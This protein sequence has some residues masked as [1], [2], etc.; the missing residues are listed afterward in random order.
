MKR[1]IGL[2]LPIAALRL[3]AA[4][5]PIIFV[6]GHKSEADTVAGFKTWN[7]HDYTTV[8]QKILNSHYDGYTAGLPLNCCENTEL[9]PTPDAKRIY[10]FSYYHPQGNPG[11]I[12]LSEQKVKVYIYYD[13][14]G[15]KRVSAPYMEGYP[16]DPYDHIE[17]WPR[18]LPKPMEPSDFVAWNRTFIESWN[19]GRFAKRLADFI[20]KVL[21]KTGATK[22]DIVAHSMGGLV[23]RVAIKNYG[24][25]SKV[26]KLLM[27]ATPNHPFN[28]PL[29]TTLFYMFSGDK[30]WQKDG[31]DLEMNANLF[32]GDQEFI[33]LW[34]GED[35]LWHDWLGYDNY[36]SGGMS[37]IRGERKHKKIAG[38][39][40]G[41]DDGVVDISQAYLASATFNPIIYASHGHSEPHDYVV[42]EDIGASGELSLTECTYTTEFI[43]KW[44]I[45]DD[46]V[47]NGAF[48]RCPVIY[49]SQQTITPP[50]TVLRIDLNAY[51]YS[52]VLSILAKLKPEFETWVGI[53][54]HNCTP[55][56]PG[57][58]VFSLS[59]PSQNGYYTLEVHTYDMEGEIYYFLEEDSLTKYLYGNGESFQLQLQNP[60]G[61]EV[62]TAGESYTVRWWSNDM[63]ISQ[64]LYY[65][66]DSGVS[67][68]HF[69]S[70]NTNDE[71]QREADWYPPQVVTYNAKIKLEFSLDANHTFSRTSG[72]FTILAHPYNLVARA[73]SE[74]SIELCW[75]NP[76]TVSVS[77]DSIQIYRKP[78]LDGTDEYGR[79]DKVLD[80]TSFYTDNTVE[81]GI[82][83]Y[84]KVRAYVGSWESPFSDE[85]SAT[86]P[87]LSAPTEVTAAGISFDKVKL[88]WRDNSNYEEKYAI[89]R[90]IAGKSDT[91][92]WVDANPGTGQMEFI[93]NNLL[94]GTTYRYRIAAYETVH[95][96]S[97]T[98]YSKYARTFPVATA[99]QNGRK[100]ATFDN[101]ICMVYAMD[102][103]IWYK[104]SSNGG[105]NWSI[106]CL[107][108]E[109]LNCTHPA[110][111]ITSSGTRFVVWT[112]YDPTNPNRGWVYR[113]YSNDGII[114]EEPFLLINRWETITPPSIAIGRGDTVHMALTYR[115][116]AKKLDKVDPTVLYMRVFPE[117][118]GEDVYY[119]DFPIV[120]IYACVAIDLR[121]IPHVVWQ[122]EGKICTSKRTGYHKWTKPETISGSCRNCQFPSATSDASGRL[123]C[124]W[125]A[126][127][128]LYLS[129]CSDG[130]SWTAP[131]PIASVSLDVSTFPVI[132]T[133]DGNLYVAWNDIEQ[134]NFEIYM[135]EKK[136]N[137]DWLVPINI[138]N[139]HENSTFPHIAL[140]PGNFYSMWTEG[141]EPPFE[142]K[143]E[144]MLVAPEVTLIYPNGG[145]HLEIG[146]TYTITWDIK[147]HIKE[148][149]LEYTTDGVTWYPIATIT[150]PNLHSYDWKV[151]ELPS[152]NCRVRITVTN[153]IGNTALDESDANFSI[154]YLTSDI[155]E[156]TGYNNQRKLA[157]DSQD[158]LHLVFS[159]DN[160]VRYARST[161]YGQSWSDK[162][163]IGNGRFPALAVDN[164][165]KKNTC[166]INREGSED[167]LYY[168]K[169][170]GEP[171]ELL[172][173]ATGILVGGF[174]P[175]A[176]VVDD[177]DW[178]HIALKTVKL[179]EQGFEYV[180]R[181]RT[182]PVGHPE[183]TD[184][185][186]VASY[187]TW[188]EPKPLTSPSVDID[189]YQ[190]P[191]IAFTFPI[192][193]EE[194]TIYYAVKI[195]G[196]WTSRDI[197]KGSHPSM[198]IWD[199]YTNVV[200]QGE[201]T[202]IYHI[203]GRI[204]P[205]GI[206][207]S[208]I[209]KISDS[210][211]YASVY[212]VIVGGCE[213]LWSEEQP[214][215]SYQIYE[216]H[217]NGIGWEGPHDI[218]GIHTMT[219]ECFPQ[220]DI[221]VIQPHPG[222]IG[223]K[224]HYVYTSGNEAPYEIR[225]GSKDVFVPYLF[226][227]KITEDTE[228][229]RDVYITGDVII[230]SGVT[231]TIKPGVKIWASPW[232]DD[233]SSGVDAGRCEIIVNGALL[234]VGTESD[235]IRF[236]SATETPVVGDWYGIRFSVHAQGE[237][238]YCMV[239]Y[240]STGIR[241]DGSSPI[242]THNTIEQ[243]AIGIDIKNSSPIIRANT[244]Q[245]NRSYGIYCWNS[246]AIIDSN[247][248]YKNS[249][250]ISDSTKLKFEPQL[251]TDVHR[252]KSMDLGRF[253]P[254][255]GF[256]PRSDTIEFEGTGIYAYESNLTLTNNKIVDNF[257]GIYTGGY[258]R[259]RYEG[260][261]VKDNVWHGLDI[262]SPMGFA[263]EIKNNTFINNGWY[264]YPEPLAGLSLG[265]REFSIDS[266]WAIVTGNEFTDNHIGVSV[267]RYGENPSGA[268]YAC[269]KGNK[270]EHNLYGVHSFGA[271]IPR[272]RSVLTGNIITDC[273]SVG[274]WFSFA[275]D[276]GLIDLGNLIDADTT[277]QGMNQI[278][279][280][281]CWNIYVDR[282]PYV[283]MAQGNNWVTTCKA[284]EIDAKIYDDNENP[285]CGPVDFSYF[286]TWG[287]IEADTTFSG[288]VSIGGELI[289]P[290]DK[291]LTIEPGTTVRFAAGI[292]PLTG[293]SVEGRLNAMGTEDSPIMFTSDAAIPKADDWQGIT[294]RTTDKHG[295][296]HKITQIMGTQ[297][298]QLIDTE[299]TEIQLQI[300]DC[301]LQNAK[302]GTQIMDTEETELNSLPVS[303]LISLLE[304]KSDP[305]EKIKDCIV[306]YAYR[307]I[308]VLDKDRKLEVQK[309]RISDCLDAGV[310]SLANQLSLMQNTIVHNGRG[311]WVDKGKTEVKSSIITNS[312]DAGVYATNTA[313]VDVKND[314]LLSNATGLWYT[315]GSSGE[316]KNS[317]IMDNETGILTSGSS[318]PSVKLTNIV[319]NT[320]YGV[321]IDE[322]S[323]PN[324]GDK[325]ANK[326]SRNV[327][328][329]N[330]KY[331]VYNNTPN[332]IWA[333]R[334]Y[335]GTM[336]LD[337]IKTHIFD[338]YDNSALGKVIFEPLWS[339]P[340]NPGGANQVIASD[341]KGSNNQYTDPEAALG[342]PDGG[343]VSLGV[344]GWIVLEM[345]TTIV[346]GP[347]ADFTVYEGAG[348]ELN[349]SFYI[350]GSNDTISWTPL[351][352]GIGT[353]SFDLS[354]S[355]L[356]QVKYIKIVDDG[357]GDSLSSA[358]GYDLD[359]VVAINGPPAGI[360][361]SQLSVLNIQNLFQ[362]SPNPF[363][364]E[365]KIRFG[366][367]KKG[368]VS[369]KIYDISG[370]LVKTLVNSKK[371]PGYYNVSFDAKGLATGIYF[372]K[373][374]A[375]GGYTKTEKLILM[376]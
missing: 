333:Q 286:Y 185:E 101:L 72:S 267:R 278:Y 23:A 62:L 183:G 138:S 105:E 233:Q 193:E 116:V 66:L 155:A 136:V 162:V 18:Y 200:W 232:S 306:E 10:N 222:V 311:I 297:I 294:F 327:I 203:M 167:V 165:G 71:Q 218:D 125:Q 126:G 365:A 280:N 276:S 153:A 131:L 69:L 305:K 61:G 224:L 55:G 304:T 210:P 145:E 147:N 158:N 363:G 117:P 148:Q 214:D 366:L 261:M 77:I 255:N 217:F 38:V 302:M 119:P 373:F 164:V 319:D 285:A 29:E 168:C 65:S 199:G 251:T 375:G 85:K 104:E 37:V 296:E 352:S 92:I 299:E 191:H 208:R 25:R 266:S 76:V 159:D 354:G 274:V 371:E 368:V 293:L 110:I 99:F 310:Y 338:Y 226:S 100:L 328:H 231:L 320:S 43:K 374:E 229:T 272:L 283:T 219:N 36:I 298:T 166:W 16:P 82:T 313:V 263:L 51:E 133:W 308:S 135:S 68:Q 216:N 132:S 344:G 40:T 372:A 11:V 336:D 174:A 172:R 80:G 49:P 335:W 202:E 46:V 326:E 95:G 318:S 28:N 346:D 245:L 111:A 124:I 273:D 54:T 241:C 186:T 63:A 33:D 350:F 198:E 256:F 206:G 279:N 281:D 230:D 376:H 244:I 8:M 348:E 175:P 83:Y 316:V 19:T 181:Y 238:D 246:S 24:C 221:E 139:T 75:N 112:Q 103:K 196:S 177:N 79:I 88:T 182:F 250:A 270:F 194:N 355:G 137:E 339:G 15:R 343:F 201:D 325:N 188:V 342:T 171:Q 14:A 259:G 142:I 345:G 330:S 173:M 253:T 235:S 324:L 284:A 140:S 228:W 269:I 157:I 70:S 151:P 369:L 209:R 356:S 90:E 257:K 93:D 48:Q 42:Y 190:R 141:N 225:Y 252:Y 152:D 309:C 205:D 32:G 156:A 3:N 39:L 106:T 22:V 211:Y 204:K 337:E 84:Y 260:N 195:G 179:V 64:H 27:V 292:E 58:P 118:E 340:D 154:C 47:I 317:T 128:K 86:T 248:I 9:Q 31:E 20:D 50:Q 243:N 312:W 322:R 109:L 149:K 347:C 127:S 331:D 34:N 180:I 41:P 184:W 150:D 314:T 341:I 170:F 187:L 262:T 287:P 271:K 362:V 290:A 129:T 254:I 107:S 44:M 30:D 300:A 189:E 239:E 301:K 91:L 169:N 97:D 192:E 45:D 94:P 275:Y 247:F 329:N 96:F 334:N 7:P 176:I 123:F 98:T 1:L 81:R 12:G 249:M 21:T 26:R 277:N 56:T 35:M 78:A 258:T 197:A 332:T 113:V 57:N 323:Q 360:E 60:I 207:W 52:N 143:F 67:W 122:Q 291:T 268:F 236:T 144:K 89:W 215:K 213:V 120:P 4:D 130:I 212:P 321:Y 115:Q 73:I 364:S 17:W 121:G 223:W 264:Q 74:N 220:A 87:W 289:V 370:R 108:G 178:V 5:I 307:G 315:N 265:F 53:P 134:D 237:L 234:A 59:R 282:C 288:I 361:E 295:C 358:P 357:D 359:A 13:G 102:G 161:D 351:G 227:S 146:K 353:A 242:I 6:H 240:A 367:P 114:W 303:Q 160:I 2:V 163:V 349:E